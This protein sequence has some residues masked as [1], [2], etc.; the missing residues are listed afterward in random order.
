MN[1]LHLAAKGGHVKTIIYLANR[2]ESLLHSIDNKGYT[3]LHWAAQKGH[4]N[5]A[6]LLL[7]DY[8]L[9]P[10]AHDKV[11]LVCMSMCVL[12]VCGVCVCVCVCPCVSVH[13]C[14]CVHMCTCVI[15]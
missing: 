13:R 3:V 8:N 12:S 1:A 6:K 4:T 10:N 2:M 9:N 14:V 15:D 11:S 5:V 7:E